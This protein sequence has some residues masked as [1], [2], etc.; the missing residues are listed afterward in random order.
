MKI[1]F[2]S[3]D[4]CLIHGHDA[5]LTSIDQ[6]IFTLKLICIQNV[7]GVKFSRFYLIYE[8]F[9]TIAITIWNNMIF[10]LQVMIAVVVDWDRGYLD[11]AWKCKHRSRW[12]VVIYHHFLTLLGDQNFYCMCM[13]HVTNLNRIS[14]TSLPLAWQF[15]C[16]CMAVE[17]FQ[18]CLIIP[19]VLR[20]NF[21]IAVM[22]ALTVF[23]PGLLV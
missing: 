3:R 5:V 6:E 21:D 16:I 1:T 20:H 14:I 10:K 17:F 4:W 12:K 9:L 8:I 18:I 7:C 2:H 13:D 19:Y 22:Y 15:L 23:R 11:M